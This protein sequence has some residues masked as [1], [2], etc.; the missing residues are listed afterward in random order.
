VPRHR[1]ASPAHLLWAACASV[2]LVFILLAA[3]AVIEPGDATLVTVVVV[4]LAA[5]L[6]AHEWRQQF[7]N[8]RR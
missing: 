5:A 6:L 8:E 2:V 7:R 3:L 4:A 1:N